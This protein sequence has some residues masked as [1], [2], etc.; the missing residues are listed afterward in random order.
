M[1]IGRHPRVTP[2]QVLGSRPMRNPNL[3]A[4]EL[5]DGGL[6]IVGQRSGRWTIRLLSAL[7]PI[8]KERRIELDSVGKQVW[9]LCDGEH[10][11][12]DMI[13]VFR[14]RHKL[15]YTEAEWSLRNYL[16]DLGK[17]GLVGFMVEDEKSKSRG[18]E[19]SQK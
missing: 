6:R 15:T 18:V 2:E 17:R 8:P 7:F 16:R 13:E 1:R 14:K 12:R 10:T 4:E 19:E 5:P 3:T 9:E 11:L